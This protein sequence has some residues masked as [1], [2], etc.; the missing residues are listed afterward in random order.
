MCGQVERTA[1]PYSVRIMNLSPTRLPPPPAPSA[2]VDAALHWAKT[3]IPDLAGPGPFTASSRFRGGDTAATD[4]LN[5]TILDGYATRRGNVTPVNTRGATGLSPYIRHGLLTLGQLWR[6]VNDAPDEDRTKFR[7]ELLWQEYARHLYARLGAATS[8]PLRHTNLAAAT[9]PDTF[10]VTGNPN[11]K[12]ACLDAARDELATDGFLVNQQRLWVAS[13]FTVRH[14]F[15]VADGEDLLYRQLLDGSRAANRLGWHWTSGQATGRAYAFTRRQVERYAPN[16][17]S[18]CA[19]NHDCPLV[20]PP[21]DPPLV[22][23]PADPRL[24]EDPDVAATAGP[25][26]PV[27]VDPTRTPKAVWLTAESLSGNDPALADNPDL[28]AVFVFDVPLLT[29]LKLA[30]KRLVFI[31]E[32]LG[33]LASHRDVHVWRGNV[34]DVLGDARANSDDDRALAA[35]FAPVPGFLPRAAQV[36]SLYPW[37]WLRRPHNGPVTSYTAWHRHSEKRA[38]R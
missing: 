14:G 33:D 23:V 4:A 30:P 34:S 37:P 7:D 1:L 29:R 27:H 6:F 11:E 17:C 25:S 8:K 9:P 31:A 36:V 16:L 38:R 3:H 2:G 5:A 32:T 28:P 13:H 12:L 10:T 24:R 21:N 35:T 22:S 26:H 19:H 15:A 20:A 18:T